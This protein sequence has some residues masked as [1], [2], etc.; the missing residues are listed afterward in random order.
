MRV[1][2]FVEVAEESSYSDGKA[3]FIC[4]I[5]SSFLKLTPQSSVLQ[6]RR[7]KLQCTPRASPIVQV[8]ALRPKDQPVTRRFYSST[9]RSRPGCYC[10][11]W[12]LWCSLVD[13]YRPLDPRASNHLLAYLRNNE[14]YVEIHNRESCMSRMIEVCCLE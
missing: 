2:R 6:Y 11:C 5:A 4:L 3:R 10:S 14:R 1:F 7:T 9:H 12:R 8:E 13:G